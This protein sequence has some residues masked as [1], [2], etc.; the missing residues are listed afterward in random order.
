MELEG[1]SQEVLRQVRA[2][3]NAEERVAPKADLYVADV[4]R[5]LEH[6]LLNPDTSVQQ[7]L[8]G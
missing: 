5:K 2:R 1:I 6:S 8:E 7:I 3:L 4:P